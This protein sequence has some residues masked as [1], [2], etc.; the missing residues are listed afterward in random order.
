MLPA[1]RR[2]IA[3]VDPNVPIAEDY[4]LTYRLEHSFKALRVARTTLAGFGSLAVFL[5]AIGLYGGLAYSVARRTREIAIRMALGADRGSVAGLVL[6]Q[7]MRLTLAGVG[8]GL[9]TAYIAS[10]FL[11]SLLYGVNPHDRLTFIAVPAVLCAV[12]LLASY[13]PARRAMRVDPMLALRY[14]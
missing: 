12:A 13:I 6:R 7:G 2:E 14:E 10:R 3:A 4:P 11:S 8:I 5:S 1:L 9:V